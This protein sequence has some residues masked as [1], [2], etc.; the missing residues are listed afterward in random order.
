MKKIIMLGSLPAIFAFIGCSGESKS[1]VPY[2]EIQQK[3]YTISEFSDK[4]LF[5]TTANP[6]VYSINYTVA[7]IGHE[8]D[9]YTDMRNKYQKIFQTICSNSQGQISQ[10]KDPVLSKHIKAVHDG[11]KMK[12]KDRVYTVTDNIATM[13]YQQQTKECIRTHGRECKSITKTYLI[14]GTAAPADT[15]HYMCKRDNQK[16][17][18]YSITPSYFDVVKSLTGDLVPWWNM[19]VAVNIKK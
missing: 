5:Q 11:K 13:I 10:V 14:K 2:S 6:N 9:P 18:V 17:F 16:L 15:T 3:Y 8:N 19:D 12:Y 1:L 7:S 4:S